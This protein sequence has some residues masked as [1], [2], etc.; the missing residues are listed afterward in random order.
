MKPTPT[1]RWS[2]RIPAA[3]PAATSALT[4]HL[5]LLPTFVGL[6]GLPEGNRPAAVRALPGRDFSALLA[7][8]ER[9]GVQALRPGVLFNYVGLST[10]DGDY[11]RQLMIATLKNT[12]D[13]PVAQ[14]KLD[15]RGFV[16][17]VFDG[18]YKFAR[19]YAPSA[20]NTPQTLEEIL[21]NNDVQLFD[22]ETDPDEMHNLAL[23][24]DKNQAT[25][26][27]MNGLLNELM[28][29]EVGVNDGRFLPQDIRPK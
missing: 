26:L 10:I 23:E 11:L 1:C 7:D 28:T 12:T 3:R 5:D 16:S 21:K 9:A 17:F 25:I 14:V 8:P 13:P 15:K 29:K 24:R 2:S 22:L 27:R 20:F 18:R 4:S 19:Y 6:T